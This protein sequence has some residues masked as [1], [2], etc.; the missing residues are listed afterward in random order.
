MKASAGVGRSYAKAL[1]E[2]ARERNQA[3]AIGR[4]LDSIVELFARDATL[5]LA[6][7]RVLRLTAR[8]LVAEPAVVV[9]TIR[10]LLIDSR[11]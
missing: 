2:L 4:E 1:F 8:R 11:R 9:A 10:T 6:G 5:Q 7:Y 3:D